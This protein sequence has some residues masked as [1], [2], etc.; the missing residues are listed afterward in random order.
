MRWPRSP[1]R[2]QDEE[3]R[4]KNLPSMVLMVSYPILSK[5]NYDI[6]DEKLQKL[7]ATTHLAIRVSPTFQPSHPPLCERSSGILGAEHDCERALRTDHGR[8]FEESRCKDAERIEQRRS[9]QRAA[10]EAKK[11]P[12]KGEA[13]AAEER[14]QAEAGNEQWAAHRTAW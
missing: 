2:S 4:M 14:R 11:R 1:F 6:R 5:E 10:A 12:R 8:A 9:K 3:H 7:Q 13:R